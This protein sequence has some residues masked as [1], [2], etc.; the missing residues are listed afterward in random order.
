MVNR[1]Q[2]NSPSR[3]TSFPRSLEDQQG[4]VVSR[5]LSKALFDKGAPPKYQINCNS[6][7][8]LYSFFWDKL[9]FEK[10]SRLSPGWGLTERLVWH[11]AATLSRLFLAHINT[12]GRQGLGHQFLPR[13][14]L[15][16][17]LVSRKRQETGHSLELDYSETMAVS[18]LTDGGVMTAPSSV[19]SRCRIVWTSVTM[20][21]GGGPSHLTRN[22]WD[23]TVHDCLSV[24]RAHTPRQ[25][26]TK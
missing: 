3:L 20:P 19:C 22:T 18:A 13:R 4:T 17:K 10:A 24:F 8:V 15:K 12:E 5:E 16:M 1:W 25:I 23:K 9:D 6:L 21:G 14:R 7:C 26:H 11:A 2:I